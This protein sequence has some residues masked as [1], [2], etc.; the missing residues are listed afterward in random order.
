MSIALAVFDSFTRLSGHTLVDKLN[1]GVSASVFNR[2]AKAINLS[3]ETLARSL[4]L[5]ART[6]RN[7]HLLSANETERAFRAYRVLLRACQVLES[8]ESARAW[9]VTPQQALGER[10]PLSLLVR[11]VG[12]EE[13]LNVLS[14]IEDGGYL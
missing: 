8:E 14:A 1:A 7:R 9:M 13:V 3:S 12:T 2:L 11:D 10:T 4:G 6:I 5:S